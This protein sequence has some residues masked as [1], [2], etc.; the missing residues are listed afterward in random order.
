MAV[1]GVDFGTM[2]SVISTARRGGID[3]ISNEVSKRETSSVVSFGEKQRFIGEKGLDQLIRNWKN[4][5]CCAKRL[6]GV[7]YDS[8]AFRHEKK[9]L[10]IPTRPD[11][12][13]L[14]EVRV[15]YKWE[16]RWMKPEQLVAMLFTQFRS[17]MEQE[18]ALESKVSPVAVKVADCVVS[19][20]VFFTTAQRRLLHNSLQISGFNPL[21]LLNETTAA[22]L[23]WGIFKSSTLPEDEKDAVVVAIVDVGHAATTCSVVSFSKGQLKVLGHVYDEFLGC[24][25]FDYAL[26]SHFAGEVKKKYHIDLDE[27]WKN[28]LRLL[29]SV[30]K[31]KK[32]LSANPVAPLNCE[33][34]EQDVQFPNVTRDFAEECW[35]SLIDR[36]KQLMTKASTL[37]GAERVQA[38]E[39]IGGGSRIPRVKS[40]VAEV[41]GK[42][43]Q[44]T[45]NTSETIAKGCGIMGAMLSPKFK[46]RDFS[47]ID[48]NVAGVNLGYFSE[49]AQT[50]I[51]D[52]KFPEINKKMAVLKPGDSFP[53]TLNLSFE[54]SSDFD[55]F[56]FYDEETGQYAPTGDSP[57]IG[58]WRIS[59]IPT[60][61]GQPHVKVRLRFNPSMLVSVEGAS[62]TEEWEEE[63]EE[64]V[65]SP[66]K[67]KEVEK[68]ESKGNK[69]EEA[70]ETDGAEKTAEPVKEKRIVK[71]KRS[72]RHECTVTLL[73]APGL[74]ETVISALRQAELDMIQSDNNVRE[75]Q[76]LKNSVESFI[77]DMRGKIQDGGELFDYMVSADREKFALELSEAE[78]WL[79]GDGDDAAKDDYTLKLNS[80]KKFS[81]P[82]VAR[83]EERKELEPAAKRLREKISELL[84][85]VENKDGSLSHIS[86]E[87]LQSVAVKCQ[88]AEAWLAPELKKAT[89]APKTQ[90]SPLLAAAVDA[91]ARELVDFASPILSKPKPKPE[92]VKEEPAAEKPAEKPAEAT[93][94]EEKKMDLD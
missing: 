29:Q 16:E 56:V 11:D 48:C 2:S 87:E 53:K 10:R 42:P 92:P 8:E 81:A 46:V 6:I 28:G 12:S 23:D 77:F 43:L 22:A 57:L 5:V 47:V 49:V 62:V 20:P 73:T 80:L 4:T 64:E 88:E 17:Y 67:E 1:F 72:K 35:E 58:K 18:V 38:V 32:M 36:L 41:W 86:P 51:Q 26:F 66:V 84:A 39:I 9:F 69:T 24:R 82:A 78:D 60:L 30:D 37:P 76:E 13:G 44:T 70:M 25:D 54:R 50:P 75:A 19:T 85:K 91:K 68:A 61:P 63:V 90:P 14:V 65:S 31:L 71:K 83:V 7:H 55:L 89:T 34:G 45:L 3:I 79:C 33:M 40:V 15:Q 59:S 27:E 52:A 93:P 94:A 74:P 21:A